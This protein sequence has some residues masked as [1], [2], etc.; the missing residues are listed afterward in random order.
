VSKNPVDAL[1]ELAEPLRRDTFIYRWAVV[2]LSIIALLGFA[3]V[4][5]LRL[6]EKEIPDS[7]IAIVSGAV[8]AIA[9]LL[10]SRPGPA[11]PEE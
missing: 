1:E 6:V 8:G 7:F 5:V 4:F 9:A 11:N 2:S 3:G 10:P